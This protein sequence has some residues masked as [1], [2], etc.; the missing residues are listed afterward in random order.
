MGTLFAFVLVCAGVLKMQSDPNGPRGK[1][2]TP[3]LN[4]KF[5][6]PAFMLIAI[7]LVF[8][9]AQDWKNQMLDFSSMSAVASNLPMWLFVILCLALSYYSFTKNLSLIPVLGLI[10]CFYMMAQIH[11]TSWIGFVIWLV[12][13]LAIYFSYG[14][15]NSK[16]H[17]EQSAA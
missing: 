10:F 7:Y 12:V 6:L 1:F 16:L 11:Y 5:I 13:G 15:Y 4:A 2:R 14:F 8:T 9:Q 3:Y 17:K